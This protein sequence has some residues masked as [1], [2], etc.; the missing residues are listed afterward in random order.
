MFGV[1]SSVDVIE[2]IYIYI[3]SQEGEVPQYCVPKGTIFG[4]KPQ[5]GGSEEGVLVGC[6][7]SPGFDFADFRIFTDDE[8]IE[9]YPEHKEKI[10]MF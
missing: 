4:S 7:V 2:Y 10:Q 6:T 9:K 3:T 1:I 8:L 5:S